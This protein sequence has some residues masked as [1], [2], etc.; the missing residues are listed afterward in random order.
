MSPYPT[1]GEGLVW[2][3]LTVEINCT[4]PQ[5]NMWYR[6]VCI[7]GICGIEV[8]LVVFLGGINEVYDLFISIFLFPYMAKSF[9]FQ[10]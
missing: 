9:K 10:K 7:G 4:R 8:L 6:V 5:F 3:D 2:K 1:V